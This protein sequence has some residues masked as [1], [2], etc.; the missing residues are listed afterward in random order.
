MVETTAQIETHI[1][2]TREHLGANLD[3]LE[4]KIQSATDWRE[5]FQS[6]P[7]TLLG[8]AFASGVILAVATG[9]RR[10]RHGSRLLRSARSPLPRGPHAEEVVTMLDNIK[11]A[12][13]GIVATKMKDAVG[14]V[15][16]GF[17]EEFERRQGA[18][19]QATPASA[20]A[21]TH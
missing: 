18:G 1:E 20:H 2:A 11:G 14:Q 16:P 7:M 19:T 21:Q 15:V 5:Y 6:T 8:A 9:P 4:R 3:A 10:D 12:L 17:Q 13:I